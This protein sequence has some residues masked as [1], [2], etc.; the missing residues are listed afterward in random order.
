MRPR[1]RD[2]YSERG[3]V[4]ENPGSP[5]R[6]LYTSQ[7]A[8]DGNVDLIP[9]GTENLYDFI[10]SHRDSV[11]IHVILKRF[12]NGDVDALS[13][14]QGHYGDFTTLPKT[15]AELLNTMIAGESYFNSL[16]LET[17]AKFDHSFEKFMVSMDNMPDFISKLGYEVSGSSKDIGEPGTGG[18][19]ANPSDGG[20]L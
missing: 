7:V 4:I 11:D 5:V 14:V 8:D 3:R 12:A 10:Q 18:S 1:F 20:T 15:Y 13:R 19:D 17:R 16:P 9:S 2:L 6:V